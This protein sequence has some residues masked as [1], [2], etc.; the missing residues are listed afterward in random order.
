MI[1]IRV[2]NRVVVSCLIFICLSIVVIGCKPTANPENETQEVQ[3]VRDQVFTAISNSDS[4]SLSSLFTADFAL[5]SSNGQMLN[6]ESLWNMLKGLKDKGM[7]LEFT[8][9]DDVVKIEGPVAWMTYSYREIIT[10]QE[11]SDTLYYVESSV[12]RKQ[13]GAWKMALAHYSRVKK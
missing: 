3:A 7:R 9:Q 11:H 5:I 8:F 2:N 10:T 1:S 6:R 12:F 4:V 13:Q